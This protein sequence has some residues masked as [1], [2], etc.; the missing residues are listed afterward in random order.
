MQALRNSL[1]T[2]VSKRRRVASLVALAMLCSDVNDFDVAKDR[3]WGG[4][5]ASAVHVTEADFQL[6]IHALRSSL[7]GEECF[8]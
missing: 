2:E 6:L 3:S 7:L 8:G 4:L 1:G 5:L